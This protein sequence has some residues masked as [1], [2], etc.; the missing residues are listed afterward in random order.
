MR[1]RKKLGARFELM[2]LRVQAH[3]G[4]P[5]G[6]KREWDVLTSLSSL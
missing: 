4:L 5:Y 1:L 2:M 3:L 6:V